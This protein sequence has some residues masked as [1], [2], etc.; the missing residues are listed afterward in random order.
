MRLRSILCV[1]LSA[2]LLCAGALAAGGDTP[3]SAP[4]DAPS[5]VPLDPGGEVE[6]P[7]KP[8]YEIAQWDAAEPVMVYGR[9]ALE[10]GRVLLENDN[11]SSAY[12]RIFVNL[13]EDTIILD[14]VTGETRTAD[15]LKDGET[16]YAYVGP[17][18]TRSLPPIAN[19][20]L[21]L[22]NI[23]ADFGAPIYAEVQ[24]VNPGEDGKVSV[25]MTGDIILH[26]DG[27]TG[28][29]AYGTKNLPTLAD[30]RPGT[31][32]LSWYSMVMESYPAQAV[33]SK[34]MVFPC[35]YAGYTDMSDSE[36]ITVNGE[37]LDASA[38]V[39]DGVLMVPVRAFAEALGCQVLWDAA[40]PDVVAV[41]RDGA[42]LYEFT[43]GGSTATVEGDMVM[44]LRAASAARGGVTYLAA[45]DLVS[46]HNLKLVGLWPVLF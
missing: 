6:R 23:P 10:E 25:L 17:A 35:A 27:D 2:A 22:C 37:R 26:L 13:N 33:P 11:E 46:F 1:T 3:A 9:A 16:L 42:P 19:G 29:T 20:V 18:M 32:L 21:V 4:T 40:R 15:D 34:V 44:G 31:R 28:L 43:V 30:I 8:D 14:A 45:D 5:S 41:T 39:A 12:Q 24:Q 7:M 36:N 38:Y